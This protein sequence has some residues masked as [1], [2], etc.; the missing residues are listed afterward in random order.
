MTATGSR[1]GKRRC[2]SGSVR[3]CSDRS[4]LISL[5]RPRASRT[6]PATV[7]LSRS[8]AGTRRGSGTSAGRTRGGGCAALPERPVR[9]EPLSR[10]FR[11]ATG[12]T[13]RSWD[14]FLTVSA[15]NWPG[16]REELTSGRLAAYLRTQNRTDLLPDEAHTASADER[17]DA[18]LARLPTTRE[19]VA[20]L[21][22]H[23]AVL[24]G[25]AVPGRARARQR[26]VAPD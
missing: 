6:C 24:K 18:W 1:S 2:F 9:A 7:G 8:S 13:C 23:P 16:L 3:I 26:S 17:L 22:V 20:D 21:D 19:A 4:S 12:A 15:Q 11:L 25:R 14:D 10:P 5:P